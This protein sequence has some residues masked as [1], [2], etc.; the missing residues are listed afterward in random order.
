MTS[1]STMRTAA[2]EWRRK[3]ASMVSPSVVML[4][5]MMYGTMSSR[6]AYP[7]ATSGTRTFNATDTD[8]ETSATRQPS[9]NMGHFRLSHDS[10]EVSI[11]SSLSSGATE[12]MSLNDTSRRARAPRN[13]SGADQFSTSA[14]RSP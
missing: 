11:A 4:A 10:R 2:A 12:S 14:S 5:P 7:F 3:A 8:I 1:A 9:P 6:F 13:S